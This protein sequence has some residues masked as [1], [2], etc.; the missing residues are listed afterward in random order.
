M[1][2]LTQG[3]NI[4]AEHVQIPL[5]LKCYK[6][7]SGTKHIICTDSSSGTQRRVSRLRDRLKLTR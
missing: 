2:I 1:T 3:K 7:E 4:S 6:I 5:K